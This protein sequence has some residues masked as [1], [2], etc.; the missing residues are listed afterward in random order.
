MARRPLQLGLGLVLV[1]AGAYMIFSPLVV[2]EVYSR[3][4]E[5]SSQMI[6]LRASGGT[7]VGIG[8]FIA[9]LPALRPW[10]RAGLG[11]LLCSMAG[12]GLA[13]AI[14]FVLDGRPDG[15]QWVWMI[16]EVTIVVVCALVLRAKK[17]ARDAR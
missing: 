8:A 3:P 4:H 2:A 15:L 17:W 9:W 11:L 7:V 12:I 13:R 6:N 1:A 16:A 5:T 14:G 10:L